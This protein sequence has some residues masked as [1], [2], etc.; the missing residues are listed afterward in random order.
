MLFSAS[1]KRLDKVL[2]VEEAFPTNVSTVPNLE[3]IS[4]ILFLLV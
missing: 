1:V 4:L 3:L 2:V